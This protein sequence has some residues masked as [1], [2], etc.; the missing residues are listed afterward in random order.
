VF[1]HQHKYSPDFFLAPTDTTAPFVEAVE[2]TTP[3]PQ[4]VKKPERMVQ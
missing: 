4:P 3:D 2:V 1:P